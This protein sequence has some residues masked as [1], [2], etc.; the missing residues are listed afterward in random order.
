MYYSNLGNHLLTKTG[1]TFAA[2][3]FSIRILNFNN[4]GGSSGQDTTL[5]V[6]TALKY[7]LENF[8]MTGIKS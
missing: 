4:V 6:G 2:N 1:A 3:R 7:K 8:K 5:T